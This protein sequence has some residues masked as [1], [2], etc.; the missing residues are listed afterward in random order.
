MKGPLSRVSVWCCSFWQTTETWR[1]IMAEVDGAC[2][3]AWFSQGCQE[4]I[5]QQ[6]NEKSQ[7]VVLLLWLIGVCGKV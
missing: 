6:N 4:P 5:Y 1:C 2:H 3:G 7:S